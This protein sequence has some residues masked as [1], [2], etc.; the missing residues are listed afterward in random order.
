MQ[1]RYNGLIKGKIRAALGLA[2]LLSA[3][4]GLFAGS[5][6]FPAK[7]WGLSFGNS[8]EFTGL[9]FNFRDNKV[10]RIT[11]VNVTFWQPGK[12]NAESV[13]HGLSLGVI[14]GAGELRG[15][16]LGLLG[17]AANK[18]ADGISFAGLGVAAGTSL[19]GIAAGGLGV[20][21][22]SDLTGI[23]F[24]GLGVGAGTDVLGIVA[25]GL[26]V[27]AGGN[28]TGICLGGLGAGAGGSIAGITIGGIGAGA[29]QD[30]AGLNIAGIGLG[31]G[32]RL[33]GVTIA[34]GAAGAG[35][36][37]AGLTVCGLAAGGKEI[38]GL[39]IGGLAV[40]GQVLKGAQIAGGMVHVPKDG[41]LVGFAA[42]PFNFIKGAQ[43]GL[44][45][46]I[47]N[48]AFHVDGLQLGLV[49][50]VRDN[51]RGLKILPVFNTSF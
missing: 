47:V 22:G 40:G 2:L 29:G 18:S 32:K 16:Q 12:E 43:T 37:L 5:V 45:I 8:P 27:G 6:D 33:T 48:Y 11:G 10:V 9:R 46:G 4:A 25:G 21:A 14:P 26:G 24:G 31:A 15:V 23:A 51:P 17:V 30:M 7:T 28:I 39:T 50:I 20:A 36:R 41:R 13:V 42:S 49:N 1:N 3:A 38:V 34:G 19:Y 44:S 35:E